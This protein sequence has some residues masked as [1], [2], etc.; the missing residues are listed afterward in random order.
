LVAPDGNWSPSDDNQLSVLFLFDTSV[1]ITRRG[2]M[3]KTAIIYYSMSGNTEFIAKQIAK[4][5]N[6]DLIKIAP[7]KAFPSSGA[8]KFIWGG[9]SAVMKE[10]PKLLPYD[11][12]VDKYDR[13]IFGTPIWASNF[14]PPI[15]TFIKENKDK[16]A[17]K[18]FATF[19]CFSGGGAGK[20]LNKLKEYL[21]IESFSAKMVLVDPKDKS[22]AKTEEM[23]NEFCKNL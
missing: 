14:A 9:K 7:E 18:N 3:S 8:K 16:L 5:T 2:I 11:F 13:I 19:M 1:N 10:T 23:I 17:G 6:A 20:A 4:K 12:D 15:R 21:G 22:S